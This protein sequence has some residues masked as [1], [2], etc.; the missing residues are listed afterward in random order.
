MKGDKGHWFVLAAA[1]LWGTTGTAQAFAP[2]SAQPSSIGAIRLAVGGA[3]LLLFAAARG[4]LGDGKPW[5]LLPTLISAASV[6]AYQLFFFAGVAKTG[7]ATG[8]IIA[9]GSAPVLAGVL[10]VLLR[11]ERPDRRWML[12]TA[13]AI[14]GGALLVGGGEGGLSVDPVGALFA[15][16]AGASYALYAVVSKG[17]LADHHPDAVTAVVFSLGAVF[18]LP[19]LFQANLSWLAQPH[20]LA[21]ALHLGLFATAAAYALFSRGLMTTP[22]ATAVALSLAEPLAAGLLGVF[23][24]DERLPPQA[25]VGAALL[26][27]GLLLLSTRLK[28]G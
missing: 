28:T 21:A 23:I 1:I 27:G 26:L 5:R 19:I 8:A 3:A 7:V 12:A 10:G 16:G 6:A 22:V 11:G 17:L 24:L 13:L 15:L 18:L 14:A 20:G 25:M 2:A 9:I 4:V